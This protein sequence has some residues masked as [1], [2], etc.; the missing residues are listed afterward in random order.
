[1]NHEPGLDPI[2]PSLVNL[3]VYL[4]DLRKGL[5]LG[6]VFSN[7][8]STIWA[9]VCWFCV[10]VRTQETWST[11]PE[12]HETTNNA[13]CPGCTRGILCHC[14]SDLEKRKYGYN[15]I[16][17][18]KY[19]SHFD[20][21]KNSTI[22][23]TDRQTDRVTS[24]LGFLSKPKTEFLVYFWLSQL[25]F[26]W[27]WGQVRRTGSGPR[28]GCPGWFNFDMMKF[29]F[30]PLVNYRSTSIFPLKL[31]LRLNDWWLTLFSRSWLLYPAKFPTV[32]AAR[33]LSHCCAKPP[34]KIC[35]LEGTKQLGCGDKTQAD[36][37]TGFC[38]IWLLPDCTA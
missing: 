31:S 25:T 26:C 10:G 19:F 23:H 36:H 9:L 28:G 4:I 13:Y 21:L 15:P 24:F 20:K 37:C 22:S 38:V 2:N 11:R 30:Q 12:A 29:W 5:N 1:M 16:Q 32:S 8:F 34:G 27:Q 33:A 6:T 14:R 3:W 18:T 17:T 7:E 35:V